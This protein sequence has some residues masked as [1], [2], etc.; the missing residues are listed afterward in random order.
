MIC[1]V[2]NVF[3]NANI[4][5]LCNTEYCYNYFIGNKRIMPFNI[6]RIC[7]LLRK[8]TCKQCKLAISIISIKT[9]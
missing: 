4:L 9:F 5:N 2:S 3:T 1:Y 7:N 6:L 8:S